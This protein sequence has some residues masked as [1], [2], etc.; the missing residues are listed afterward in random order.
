M[1]PYMSVFCSTLHSFKVRH[2]Q[3]TLQWPRQSPHGWCVQSQTGRRSQ[4][5][6]C[7]GPSSCLLQVKVRGVNVLISHCNVRLLCHTSSLSPFSEANIEM[8]LFLDFLSSGTD[9]SGRELW[10]ADCESLGPPPWLLILTGGAGGL[11]SHTPLSHIYTHVHLH[12]REGMTMHT[13]NAVSLLHARSLVPFFLFFFFFFR[14][15]NASISFKTKML[16]RKG[17]TSSL[18]REKTETTEQQV[19]K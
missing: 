2:S 12:R 10:L 18:P 17:L 14:S 6:P 11:S 8:I 13:R 4:A 3:W 5:C 16:L 19:K 1:I 15:H 9:G 7:P